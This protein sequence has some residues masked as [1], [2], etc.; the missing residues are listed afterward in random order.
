ML[1]PLISL[2]KTAQDP[3]VRY[4]AVATLGDLKSSKA[5]IPLISTMKEDDDQQVRSQ[6]AYALGE[7]KDAKAVEFLIGVMKDDKDRTVQAEAATALGKIKDFRAVEPL[8]GALDNQAVVENAKKAL[9]EIT[10]ESFHTRS[11]WEL[12]WQGYKKKHPSTG[13]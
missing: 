2:L 12:W 9:K 8:I 10:E 4:Y 11:E 7:L 6:A 1:D 5:V 13:I 3:D